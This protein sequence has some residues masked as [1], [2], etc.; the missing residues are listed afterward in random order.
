M[1]SA[2]GSLLHI[3]GTGKDSKVVRASQ[4]FTSQL[5]HVLLAARGLGSFEKLHE[6]FG[7]Q[8]G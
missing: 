6:F 8:S 4:G 2:D 1:V 5:P 7:F 3:L